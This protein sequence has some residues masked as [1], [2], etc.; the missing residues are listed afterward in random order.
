[1]GG[2]QSGKTVALGGTIAAAQQIRTA[3]DEMVEILWDRRALILVY[4]QSTIVLRESG[5]GQTQVELSGGSVRV[6]SAYHGRPM[7]MVAVLTPSARVITRGG[8]MEVDALTAR[9]SLFA[10]SP[11]GL[12]TPIPS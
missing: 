9:P 12:A 6:A 11:P 4:P 8:I 1:M 7:D 3:A 10:Q 2:A 5:E